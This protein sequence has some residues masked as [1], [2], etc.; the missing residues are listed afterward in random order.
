MLSE[1]I[2][3][4][5]KLF[6]EWKEEKLPELTY[7]F[8]EENILMNLERPEH[9][10]LLKTFP[11]QPDHITKPDIDLLV[12]LRQENHIAKCQWLEQLFYRKV[13]CRIYLLIT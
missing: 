6:L 9:L 13:S 1:I 2:I 10:Q 3:Q 12:I 4:L 8:E 11:N 5:D 7:L